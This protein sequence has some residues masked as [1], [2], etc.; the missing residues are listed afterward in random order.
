MTA[1]PRRPGIGPQLA[2]GAAVGL[3]LVAGSA[4]HAIAQATDDPG[5]T[6]LTVAVIAF[7]LA[8]LVGM[9]KG[10]RIR[11]PKSRLRLR[12]LLAGSAAWL[13]A[14][15]AA[16]MSWGAVQILALGVTAVSLHWWR[17]HRIPNVSTVPRAVASDRHV[18]LWDKRVARAGKPLAGTRLLP[19]EA[20]ASGMQH[21]LRLIPGDHTIVTVENERRKIRGALEMRRGEDLIIEPH[22]DL[23]EP[24]LRLTVVTSQ[25]P[26]GSVVWPGPV[27]VLGRDGMIALGPFADG[28]GTAYWRAFTDTRVKGGFIQGGTGS[29]KSRLIET[30]V[31][32]LAGST[33][34]PSVLLWAD[35]QGGASSKLL[36][37]WCDKTALTVEACRR[38]L[39]GV[40]RIMEHRQDE[41]DIEELDGFTPTE[42]RPAIFVILDECHKF[43]ADAGIQA[44]AAQIAREGEKVGVAMI[45]AT[46]LAQLA[47]AF[48]GSGQYADAIRSS[49]LTANGVLM[50]GKSKSA[51]QIFNVEV[52]PRDFPARPG[53]GFLADVDE[54][55]RQA[56]FL[57]FFVSDAIQEYWPPLMLWRELDKGSAT[58]YGPEYLNRRELAAAERE[59]KRRRV[60]ARR[61]GIMPTTSAERPETARPTPST[62]FPVRKFPVWI[63]PKAIKPQPDTQTVKVAD[64]H[65]R[66]MEAV[67]AGQVGTDGYTM[68]HLVA[69]RLA[70][71]EKWA[72][73]ALKELVALGVMSRPE[74]TPQGRYYPTGKT[75]SGKVA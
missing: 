10:Q 12:L 48:G 36:R 72:G 31:M 47:A 59:E 21:T 68:P 73:I 27:D 8:V 41:N 30:I 16:G 11:C 58:I 67:A 40:I 35:G 26:I 57:G 33:L 34:F 71:S 50:R 23:P 53:Y 9:K 24:H 7:V 55:A 63:N 19:G 18:D 2:P 4:L 44:M 69:R 32:A 61:A 1:T 28:I 45:A 38:M 64:I 22:P 5:S 60:A 43:F 20:I 75:L 51:A 17:L 14:V 3:L 52:D 62:L 49:L 42:D 70:V 54:G 6:T 25:P 74:G 37:K 29:G 46:Q 39:A 15:T 13:T 56:P 66:V 65:R